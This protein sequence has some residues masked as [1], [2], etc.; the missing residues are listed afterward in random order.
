MK[1]VVDWYTCTGCGKRSYYSKKDARA[2]RRM[3]ADST[4]HVYTCDITNAWHLGHQESG[5]PRWVYVDRAY[6]KSR[7][8]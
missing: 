4:L 7:E 2:I 1:R 6:R 5:I 8:T 3:L